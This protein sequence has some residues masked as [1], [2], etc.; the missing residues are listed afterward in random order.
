MITLLI[1]L[2]FVFVL[3]LCKA[4]ARPVPQPGDV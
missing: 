3:G 4:V 1:V 2:A